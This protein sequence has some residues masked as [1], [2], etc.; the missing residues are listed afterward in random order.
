VTVNREGTQ[1]RDAIKAV[2]SKWLNKQF[3]KRPWW[4]EGG[5]AKYLWETDYFHAATKYVKDQRDF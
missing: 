4:A 1:L 3:E 5:S 2:A